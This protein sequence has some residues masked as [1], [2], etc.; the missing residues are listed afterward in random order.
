MPTIINDYGDDARFN[1]A[2]TKLTAFSL[3]DFEKIVLLDLDMLVVRNM[4][5]LMDVQLDEMNRIFAAVHSVC[6]PCLRTLKKKEDELKVSSV[7]ATQIKDRLR[8]K[9]GHRAV[10]NTSPQ[11]GNGTFPPQMPL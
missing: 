10:R 5:E 11:H 7:H 9:T 3:T 1:D 6:D 2:W 4:D 8:S